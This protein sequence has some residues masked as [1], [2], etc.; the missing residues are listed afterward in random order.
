MVAL[1]IVIADALSARSSGDTKSDNVKRRRVPINNLRVL[2]FTTHP[3]I[4]A[5]AADFKPAI[6]CY[7]STGGG[8]ENVSEFT[9]VKSVLWYS[10]DST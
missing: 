2:G 3:R 10:P 6:L 4:A 9:S 8:N 5:C 7:G 1:S